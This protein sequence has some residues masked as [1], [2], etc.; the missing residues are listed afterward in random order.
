MMVYDE[1]GSAVF[2]IMISSTLFIND[3]GFYYFHL[4]LSN[5]RHIF[6]TVIFS[7]FV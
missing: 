1:T 4:I 6:G 2:I 3:H 7:R 5:E